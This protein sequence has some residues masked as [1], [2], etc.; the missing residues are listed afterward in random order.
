MPPARGLRGF[1]GSARRKGAR[2]G[3][4]RRP[5]SALWRRLPAAGREGVRRYPRTRRGRSPRVSAPRWRRDLTTTPLAP[6]SQRPGGP[7][8]AP[9]SKVRGVERGQVRGPQE[10]RKGAPGGGGRQREG[11]GGREEDVGRRVG[12]EGLEW[13]RSRA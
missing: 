7:G 9:G 11:R 10:G 8:G 3:V 4:A 12:G 2:L 5:G 13:Q 1:G 6:E